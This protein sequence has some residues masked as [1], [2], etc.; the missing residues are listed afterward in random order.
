MSVALPSWK[1]EKVSGVCL[2]L[3]LVEGDK[4][5][6]GKK[7]EVWRKK[8]RPTPLCFAR[9]DIK[10]VITDDAVDEDLPIPVWPRSNMVN[11]VYHI[12]L[13]AG[14]NI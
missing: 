6:P 4:N 7:V 9:N 2:I 5:W 3:V 13:L 1:T 14:I 12:C 11:I 8:I 10:V